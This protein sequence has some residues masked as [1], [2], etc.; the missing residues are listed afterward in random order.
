MQD[1]IRSPLYAYII[2]FEL[3][4]STSPRVLRVA[5]CAIGS[6]TLCICCDVPAEA[7]SKKGATRDEKDKAGKDTN[8]DVEEGTKE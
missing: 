7:S 4:F 1:R 6:L 2:A 8:K 3:V 5:Y